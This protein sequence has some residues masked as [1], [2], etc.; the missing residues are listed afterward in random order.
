MLGNATLSRILAPGLD[1]ETGALAAQLSGIM[2]V[3]LVFVLPIGV[4]RAFL[5]A[6]N[7]F[8]APASHEL[9]RG[10]TIIAVIAGFGAITPA[11]RIEHLALGYTIAAL[12]QAMVFGAIIWHCLGPH[13]RPAIDLAL[14][15]AVGVKRMLTL[16]LLEQGIAQSVL[17]AERVIGSFLPAGSISALSYGHRLASVIGNSLFTG[18]EVVSLSTLATGLAT[19]TAAGL[20]QARATLLAAMRLVILVGVPIGAIIW[21]VQLPVTHLLFEREGGASGGEAARILG[22]Y[23]LT[24][25][26]Y[27]YLLVARSYW[28]ADGRPL[29]PIL[30]ASAQLVAMVSVAP[31]LATALSAP[32]VAWAY[33]IGQ[34]VA[35]AVAAATLRG[36][37]GP[38]QNRNVAWLGL[39]VAGAAL[40]TASLM[41][42]VV[43]QPPV[44]AGWTGAP[45]FP[46][47]LTT[48]VLAGLLGLITL[49]GVGTVLQIEE[50]RL[51]RGTVVAG[52]QKGKGVV[53]H[54]SQELEQE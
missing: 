32:G 1:A 3:S 54:R 53:R 2:F 40:V 23:A 10:T 34:L 21:A 43:S 5:N 46:A 48:L 7:L 26:L 16:P 52:L 51:A 38:G 4:M 8:T 24:I 49:L 18:I 29:L 39:R 11:L 22:I 17:V 27:G 47:H 20:R 37:A 6:H 19:R 12:V 41:A 44:L 36:I 30:I 45:S 9:L 25:P 35:S 42:A 33:A 13:Y 14:L 28:Y 15:R 50:L 31:F